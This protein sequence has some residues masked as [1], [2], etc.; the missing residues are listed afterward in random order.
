[1]VWGLGQPDATHWRQWLNL[2][3]AIGR[4][5]G[6]NMAAMGFFL[7]RAVKACPDG[8]LKTRLFSSRFEPESLGS[9]AP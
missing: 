6:Q 3:A 4:E 2:A 8:V 1:M 5:R 9:S 7:N